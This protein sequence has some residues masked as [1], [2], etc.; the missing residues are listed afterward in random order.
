MKKRALQVTLDV[1]EPSVVELTVGDRVQVDQLV[2]APHGF[3]AER[4]GDLF[5]P[6]ATTISLAKGSY[7]FRTLSDASLRLV[8]GGVEAAATTSSKTDIPTL[9]AKGA[10]EATT[11]ECETPTLTIE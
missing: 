4:W 5:G 6:G 7:C 3:I 1:R 8:S 2:P 9:P 11:D 10:L